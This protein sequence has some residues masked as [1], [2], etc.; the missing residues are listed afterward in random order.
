MAEA[1][2]P[3]PIRPIVEDS[4]L[5]GPHSTDVHRSLVAVYGLL[6]I[7][8]VLW[9]ALFPL[10]PVYRDEL[11]LSATEVGILLAAFPVAVL[12][13]SLPAGQLADRVGPL[14]VTTIAA[15]TMAV[16]AIGQWAAGEFSTLLVARSLQGL[17]FGAI[18][19]AGLA[20][21]QEVL[22]VRLRAR[23]LSGS[24]V[25]AGLAT[26]IGPTFGGALA[27]RFHAGTPFLV[28]GV[29]TVGLVALLVGLRDAHVADRAAT[30]LIESAVRLRRDEVAVAGF[31]FMA[32]AGYVANTIHLLVPLDL[33]DVGMGEAAI[34]LGLT[35]GA[36]VFLCT[37]ITLARLG[38]RAARV[39]L[40]AIAAA[41][42]GL[43]CVIP[44]VSTE[45]APL[46]VLLG[47]RGLPLATLFSIA[48]PLAA[49]G[50][51]R[52]GVGRAGVLGIANA[53]W[54]VAAIAGPV[55]AGLL[56]DHVGDASPWILN[57]FLCALVV[58]WAARV[59]QPAVVRG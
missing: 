3:A 13:V 35:V 30:P 54:A 27:T 23:I 55:V 14:R 21:L 58:A 15:L 47:A 36:G 59:R 33:R 42:L 46:F 19:P 50:G 8:D 49:M 56:D 22:P 18:W 29:I 38:P 44:I 41:V 16:G 4:A 24:M 37:S 52:V 2:F 9:S 20:Y 25:V 5:T 10:G 28:G 40:G 26:M 34:G 51:D 12:V 17:G 43:L 45:A 6:V 31:A 39:G 1:M 11:G 48:A 53:I 32:L 57:I 7:G